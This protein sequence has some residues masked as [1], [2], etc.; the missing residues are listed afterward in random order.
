M[1]KILSTFR[2]KKKLKYMYCTA[3]KTL[4]KKNIKKQHGKN[5]PQCYNDEVIRNL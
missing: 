4:L 5:T 3:C 1:N 2:K